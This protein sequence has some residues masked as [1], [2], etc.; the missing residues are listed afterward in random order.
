MAFE[1]PIQKN[2]GTNWEKKT[3]FDI[4]WVLTFLRNKRVTKILIWTSILLT[5]TMGTIIL[6][7]DI[8]F[9]FNLS[10]RF[11]TIEEVQTERIIQKF[12]VIEA[13]SLISV[14]I[15]WN[16]WTW[17]TSELYKKIKDLYVLKDKLETK[18]EMYERLNQRLLIIERIDWKKAIINL[19]FKESLILLNNLLK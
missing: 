13:K 5:I 3:S 8:Q 19:N 16:K 2:E 4:N 17:T 1:E 15:L 14:I 10:K 7:K 18:E 12:E 11:E 6:L 9:G